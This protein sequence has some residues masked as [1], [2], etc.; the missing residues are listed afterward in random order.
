[1]NILSIDKKIA[2]LNLILEGC[3]IRTT[4]RVTGVQRDT[5][6]RLCIHA[7]NACQ[8]LH[9][10]CFRSLKVRRVE[11][12]ELWSFVGIKQKNIPVIWKDRAT[13]GDQYLYIAFDADTKLI[14][15]YHVGKRTRTEVD[16]FLGDL[17]K[18]VS[19]KF[20]LCSDMFN[21]YEGS[22][23]A[24]FGTGVD[25][26]QIVKVYDK[27]GKI[28]GVTS[29]VVYGAPIDISTTGVER[30]NLT[31]RMGIKRLARKTNAFSKKLENHKAAIALFIGYYN[32]CRVHQGMKITPAMASG[33][34]DEPWS[35]KDLLTFE[36]EMECIAASA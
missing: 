36:T 5:I 11:F 10:N 25:Y 7:G 21:P 15:S 29:R 22:I 17:H 33:I 14:L 8:Q 23:A 32:L 34:T 35:I 6:I 27:R 18:R 12:D 28:K 4:E 2:V 9:E 1:M 30:N 26:G 3:S 16:V 13:T 20:Q 24:I 31:L 19:G